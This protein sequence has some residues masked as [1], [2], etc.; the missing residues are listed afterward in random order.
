M[1]IDLGNNQDTT[2]QAA[3]DAPALSL[4]LENDKKTTSA[5]P[6][7][8]KFSVSEETIEMALRDHH[9]PGDGS[10]TGRGRGFSI[11]F[12]AFGMNEDEPIPNN[13]SAAATA[14]PHSSSNGGDEAG[15]VLTNRPRGDSIIFDPSSFGEGGI[16]EENALKGSH[17]MPLTSEVD[18][19]EIMN[20]PGFSEA[21][22]DM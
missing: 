17:L 21:Q 8:R 10:S 5:L 2:S 19:M 16:H 9:T 15:K 13:G 18:E 14:T 1:G 4:A 3:E 20:A 12:F 11:D 6:S 7:I 22:P